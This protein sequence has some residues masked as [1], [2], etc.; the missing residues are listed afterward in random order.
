MSVIASR[1]QPDLRRKRINWQKVLVIT[2]FAAVPLFLLILFI[3]ILSTVLFADMILGADEVM[4][5]VKKDA[6]I[7][8]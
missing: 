4:E 3:L 7:C 8:A 6:G 5:Y 2:L 1:V